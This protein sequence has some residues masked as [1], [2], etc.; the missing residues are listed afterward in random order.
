MPTIEEKQARLAQLE[1]EEAQAQQLIAQQDPAMQEKMNQL[2][3]LEQEEAMA[4]EMLSQRPTGLSP[5]DIAGQQ[6]TEP[7]IHK[8]PY[9][10]ILGNP[11]AELG[12]KTRA[13][14]AIEPLESN[15]KALLAEQFGPENLFE[16]PEGVVFLQQD[17][18]LRP[19]NA[20]GLSTGDIAELIGAGPEIVGAGMA[21]LLASPSGPGAYPAAVGGG[22]AGATARQAISAGL[23]TPQVAS[24]GERV[25]DVALSGVL[26]GAGKFVAGKVKP[27]TKKMVKQYFPSASKAGKELSAISKRQGL[28]EPSFGQK[29]GGMA[30]TEEKIMERLPVV[31]SKYRKIVKKQEDAI[32]RNLKKEAGDFVDSESMRFE[33]SEAVK[34]IADA[35]IATV[36]NTASELFEEVA[37]KGAKVN[38]PAK[39]VRESFIESVGDFFDMDGKLKKFNPELG[40]SQDEFGRVQKALSPI[41]EGLERDTLTPNSINA[42]R[43]TIDSEIRESGKLGFSDTVLLKSKENFLDLSEKILEGESP[44]MARKFKSA[45]A[46]WGRHLQM[47][48]VYE[49][50]GKGS[51]SNTSSDKLVKKVFSSPESVDSFKNVTDQETIE[52]MGGQFLFDLMQKKTRDGRVL[53]SVLN[54]IKNN[55]V[56]IQKVFGKKKYNDLVDNVKFLKELRV[57]PNP[58]G[59]FWT[60]LKSNPIKT[61]M[62]AGWVG[63]KLKARKS[64]RKIPQKAAT[65]ARAAVQ[66]SGQEKKR[67]LTELMRRG[68]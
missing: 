2:A 45:R 51:L 27:F 47:K 18:Q 10:D 30:R 62:T 26:S 31:G 53:P 24:V 43:K 11:E 49:K 56:V 61:I 65:A 57:D 16:T 12:F 66:T 52:K 54:D 38:I 67:G 32:M 8:G 40:I 48:D 55:R 44:D 58:S 60:D 22:M 37:E 50:G 63:T 34:D 3:L 5:R 14:Y 6:A 42:F 46:L 19:I 7:I 17:G 28:P 4:Q 36:K 21:G 1:Q 35:K 9:A 41:I 29:V 59:T 15:R 13:K 23:G 25:G 64:V 68:E 39:P 33:L 20:P